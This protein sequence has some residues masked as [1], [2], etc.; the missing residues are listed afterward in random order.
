M[1]LKVNDCILRRD[2]ECHGFLMLIEERIIENYLYY[3]MMVGLIAYW[4]LKNVNV[5]WT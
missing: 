5:I 3:V 1:Q 4:T 2:L